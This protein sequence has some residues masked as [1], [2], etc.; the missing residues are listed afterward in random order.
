[1]EAEKLELME[2]WLTVSTLMGMDFD[3]IY[4]D[5]YDGSMFDIL[6]EYERMQQRISEPDDT[7]K[8]VLQTVN[9]G[10]TSDMIEEYVEH[11]QQKAEEELIRA[12]DERIAANP[13]ILELCSAHN[14]QFVPAGRYKHHLYFS[15]SDKSGRMFQGRLF[16]QRWNNNRVWLSWR[17]S[18]N[19]KVS[20]K[21]DTGR[22]GVALPKGFPQEWNDWGY[23]R[24]LKH[25][26]YSVAHKVINQNMPKALK[27]K[28]PK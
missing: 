21:W 3:D 27:F 11:C 24:D 17:D 18:K 5:Y 7:M 4:E 19:K 28:Y 9:M 25:I 2:K 10:V 12:R 15:F 23:A 14:F 22:D 1:M 6:A 8:V 20:W 13:A 26:A 16:R